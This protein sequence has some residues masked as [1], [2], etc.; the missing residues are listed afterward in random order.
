MFSKGIHLIVPRIV[1]NEKV[2]AFFDDTERL[3]YVIPMGSGLSS[4]QRMNASSIRLLRSTRRTATSS[5]N[6]STSDSTCRSR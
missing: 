6:R 5:S 4:A 3:F 1:S 2:L